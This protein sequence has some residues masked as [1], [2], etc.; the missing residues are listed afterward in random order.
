MPMPATRT[1][2]SGYHSAKLGERNGRA[3][4]TRAIVRKLRRMYA[5][6]DASHR[7]LARRFGTCKSNVGSILTYQTWV[8]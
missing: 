3:I 8:E 1:L 7:D 5:E 6:G 4:L 2:G